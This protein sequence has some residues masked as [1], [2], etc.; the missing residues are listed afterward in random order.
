MLTLWMILMACEIPDP[1]TFVAGSGFLYE[2]G[3]QTTSDDT[4][5]LQDS[6]IEDSTFDTDLED[7]ANSE[8][9]T[10]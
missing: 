10:Q 6:D 9:T 2:G 4:G 3:T 8:D 7:T 5:N 1:S